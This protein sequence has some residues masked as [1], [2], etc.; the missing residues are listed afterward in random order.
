MI[1]AIGVS[2]WKRKGASQKQAYIVLSIVVG[3]IGI[4]CIQRR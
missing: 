3:N 1:A 4:W 2:L